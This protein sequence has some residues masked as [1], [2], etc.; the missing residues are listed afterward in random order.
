MSNENLQ[1]NKD[2]FKGFAL[3]SDIEDVA[4][5]NRNRAVVLANMAQDHCKNNLIS[6]NGAGLIL[7]YFKAVPAEE[8]E[9]LMPIFLQQMKERGFHMVKQ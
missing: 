6:P 1:N 5:R 8:R 2:T 9:G 4:L 7:G 3:F